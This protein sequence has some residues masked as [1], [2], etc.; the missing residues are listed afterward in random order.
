[1]GFESFMHRQYAKS[2]AIHIF[3]GNLHQ[4]VGQSE[5]FLHHTLRLCE[6]LVPLYY[7]YVF[8]MF[9][10]SMNTDII[11]MGQTTI[12]G[13]YIYNTCNVDFPCTVNIMNQ[14]GVQ[15]LL[16]MNSIKSRLYT[17]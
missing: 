11:Y 15:H 12:S 3:S 1:M 16:N 14:E 4:S 7:G 10:V 2:R 13:I 9:N 5:M 6:H 8:N 17:L